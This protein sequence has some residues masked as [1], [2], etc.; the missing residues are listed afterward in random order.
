MH[1]LLQ[2]SKILSWITQTQRNS[3]GTALSHCTL[4][5]DRRKSNQVHNHVLL[6]CALQASALYHRSFPDSL[7]HSFILLLPGPNSWLPCFTLEEQSCGQSAG[8]H[9]HRCL[10]VPMRQ[11]LSAYKM[12][13][14]GEDLK[15]PAWGFSNSSNLPKFLSPFAW[16]MARVLASLPD[17][18]LVPTALRAI[19]QKPKVRTCYFLVHELE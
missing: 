5:I 10:H 11:W 13:G 8:T 7:F 4:C 9:V 19:L 6:L 18:T 12:P 16:I 14:T 17:V 15:M 2:L 3:L 1:V